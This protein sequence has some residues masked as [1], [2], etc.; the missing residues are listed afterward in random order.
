MVIV[1]LASAPAEGSPTVRGT[2]DAGVGWL[3]MFPDP[4]FQGIPQTDLHPT[5][6]CTEAP[7]EVRSAVNNFTE[8]VAFYS[9]PHCDEVVSVLPPIVGADPSIDRGRYYRVVTFP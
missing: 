1:I 6:K 2:A 8:A 7:F 3:A 4:Y 9:D 5:A